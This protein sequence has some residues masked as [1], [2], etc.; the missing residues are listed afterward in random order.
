MRT[1]YVLQNTVMLISADEYKYIDGGDITAN[2]TMLVRAQAQGLFPRTPCTQIIHASER[3]EIEPPVPTD[4]TT[5]LHFTGPG[6]VTVPQPGPYKRNIIRSSITAGRFPNSRKYGIVA[7][8]LKKAG[9]EDSIPT[10]YRPISNLFF[11]SKLLERVVYRRTTNCLAEHMSQTTT[12]VQVG[13]SAPCLKSYPTSS[14]RPTWGQFA[15]QS[16]LDL[17]VAFDKVNQSIM[18]ERLERS[19]GVRGS[20]LRW[21]NPISLVDHNRCTGPT[22]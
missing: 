17:S 12:R 2:W 6:C 19:S 8:L 14:T 15:L 9:L 16:L 10:N 3:A 13:I 7:P 4:R 11:L 21:S 5:T 20:S 22:S 1:N 18:D